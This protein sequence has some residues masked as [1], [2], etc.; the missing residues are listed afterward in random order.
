[1]RAT[2]LSIIM[3][4]AP[5]VHAGITPAPGASEI[6]TT[7]SRSAAD[8][9]FAAISAR[10]ANALANLLSQAHEPCFVFFWG[11]R[12]AGRDTL[13][14]WHKDWFAEGTWSIRPPA[15]LQ[16]FEG[17]DLAVLSYDLY[18]D[19]SADRVFRLLITLTLVRETSGWKIASVQQTM[20][21]GPKD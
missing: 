17:D 9:L 11:E 3:L 19:K 2:A 21:E 8:S 20:L 13:I 10:D 4:A 5:Q 14:Q 15:L 18:Y 7:Q 16:G 12:V 6:G 1:M